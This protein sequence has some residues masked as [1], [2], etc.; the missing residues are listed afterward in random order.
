MSLVVVETTE[1]RFSPLSVVALTRRQDLTCRLH[2]AAEVLALHGLKLS[3]VSEFDEA[4]KWQP[5]NDKC[6]L[7][8]D[9]TADPQAM[10]SMPRIWQEVHPQ[11][12]T[13]LVIN[14]DD[15]ML[16]RSASKVG[17]AATFSLRD[18]MRADFLNQLDSKAFSLPRVESVSVDYEAIFQEK[19]GAIVVADRNGRI[20]FTNEDF[21]CAAGL[22]NSDTNGIN[23]ASFFPEITPAMLCADMTGRTALLELRRASGNSLVVDAGFDTPGELNGSFFVVSFSSSPHR[24]KRL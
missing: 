18:A 9:A 15:A 16:A 19:E 6:L 23:L 24:R 13:V 5:K 17:F 12:R 3:I 4:L 20:V 21:R 2:A 11:G 14:H 8:V 1:K 10:S 22:M 7:I